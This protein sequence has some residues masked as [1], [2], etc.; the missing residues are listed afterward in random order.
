MRW[1][2]PQRGM[3]PRSL[4]AEPVWRGGGRNRARSPG[5]NRIAFP[6]LTEDSHH[7]WLGA[8]GAAVALAEAA[9]VALRP[10]HGVIAAHPGQAP[11]DFGEGRHPRGP[12]L[13]RGA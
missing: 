9:V 11:A 5:A 7:G 3:E 1:T 10:R 12:R 4:A 6:P 13:G 8:L 2:R